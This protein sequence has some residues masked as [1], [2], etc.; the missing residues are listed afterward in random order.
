MR[1]S[2]EYIKIE[3]IEVEQV[4]VSK[5]FKLWEKG[6]ILF[7]HASNLR[8]DN[9]WQEPMK[10]KKTQNGE[11]WSGFNHFDK[12]VSEFTYYQC[13]NERGKYPIF[14]AEKKV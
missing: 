2:N 4:N 6:Y 7:I 3:G 12:V 14:F 5:A 10:I 8:I 13:D 1:Y 11:A 9:M